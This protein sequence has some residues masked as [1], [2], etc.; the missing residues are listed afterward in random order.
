MHKPGLGGNQGIRQPYERIKGSQTIPR[1]FNPT[2]LK[3]KSRMAHKG[4]FDS[5]AISENPISDL[6][7]FYIQIIPGNSSCLPITIAP[8]KI[9]AE[10]WM[11]TK[12]AGPWLT[13]PWDF[14]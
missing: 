11:T 9:F 1:G 8:D 2:I 13:L 7:A 14:Q 5:F 6:A 4:F 3:S 10:R 12:K